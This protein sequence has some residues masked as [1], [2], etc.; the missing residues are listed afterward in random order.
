MKILQYTLGLPPYRRGGLT[1]YSVDLSKEL[2]KKNE[3]ILLYPGKMPFFSSSKLHFYDRKNKK[4]HFRV[5]EMENPLPVSLGLGIDTSVPYMNKRDKKNIVTFLKKENPDVIHIHTLMGLPLEF[6]EVAKDLNIKIVY[7]THDFYG[8]CPKMLKDNSLE[9][10]K[11]RQ[12]TYDCML[13][14]KGPALHKIKIMQSHQY[15]RLKNTSLISLLRKYKKEQ[16]SSIS[17][18]GRVSDEE[19]KNRYE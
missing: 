3:V 9:L 16:V 6:L 4:Y 19:S 17:Y 12:C 7:T 13:C 5:V 11:N 14:K 1:R 18:S 2:S 15:M 8:L 10:L